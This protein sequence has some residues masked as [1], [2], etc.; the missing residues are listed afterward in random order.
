MAAA[1]WV[2]DDARLARLAAGQEPKPELDAD[3]NLK[4]ALDYDPTPLSKC[5]AT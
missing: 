4:A 3:D 1:S 5:S 2:G